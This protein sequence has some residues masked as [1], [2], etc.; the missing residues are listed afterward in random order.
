M[1]KWEVIFERAVSREELNFT[2]VEAIMKFSI[3][4]PLKLVRKL[5]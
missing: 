5:R 1:Q 2:G 3:K 4:N